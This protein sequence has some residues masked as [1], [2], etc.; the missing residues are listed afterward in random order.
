MLPLLLPLTGSRLALALV[1]LLVKDP[2]RGAME[3]GQAVVEGDQADDLVSGNWRHIIIDVY[4]VVK[5]TPAL[6]WTMIGAVFLHIP[7]GA[8]QFA[9]V[10]L[11][12]ERGFGIGEISAVY[13]LI[14]IVFGTFLHVKLCTTQLWPIARPLWRIE[15]F[16]SHVEVLFKNA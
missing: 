1:L 14:Y 9:I 16:G 5:S 15:P 6:L 3:E 12:R 2:K 11:E 10:W 7:M 4:L 13:G 8:G